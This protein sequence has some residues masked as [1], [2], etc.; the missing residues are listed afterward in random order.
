[1]V[2]TQSSGPSRIA[3]KEETE[4]KTRTLQYNYEWKTVEDI[5]AHLDEKRYFIGWGATTLAEH[6]GT[7]KE[8]YIKADKAWQRLKEAFN[9]EAKHYDPETNYSRL[10]SIG[11]VSKREVLRSVWWD[12]I[13]GAEFGDYY[14]I[15]AI[16]EMLH[17]GEQL[18]TGTI[19]FGS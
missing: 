14:Q 7:D 18:E 12:A 2:A 1:M 6:F 8:I 4:M 9:K 19:I 3:S 5:L 17:H 11:D 13:G 15:I 10:G 16:V